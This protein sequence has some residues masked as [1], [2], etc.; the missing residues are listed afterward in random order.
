MKHIGIVACSAEGASLCYRSI[1]QQALEYLGEHDHPRI[2]LDSIP[3]ARTMPCFRKRDMAGV[4]NILR[5][6]LQTLAGAGVDF[7]ICPDNTCH[8]SF[9]FLEQTVPVPL[10]HIVRVVG[11]E[12]RRLGYKKLGIT[13]TA[14]LMDGGLYPEMLRRE[15]EMDSC[16]PDAAARSRIQEIIFGQL[17]N[18]GR[19]A[20]V[21]EPGYR[22]PC[23]SGLRR[24]G[25][26]MHRTPD[27][28]PSRRLSVAR[29]RF[30]AAF[31]AQGFAHGT[32]PR[33]MG[34]AGRPRHSTDLRYPTAASIRK[35]VSK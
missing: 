17:V 18:A 19:V 22:R 32:G 10:L 31:G 26:G 29:A 34:Q 11:Q 9:P 14:F 6:S 12:A 3:M 16:I 1:C 30:H 13:G 23:P 20:A 25:T 5:Q 35:I 21:P 33:V 27:P 4:A 28:G 2:T 15:F 8:L 7:A 24:C